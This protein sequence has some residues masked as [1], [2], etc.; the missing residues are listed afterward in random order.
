MPT[1]DALVAQRHV[2][3][4]LRLHVG[5][6]LLELVAAH[7]VADDVEEGQHARLASDR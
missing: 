4:R 2:G 1:I 3:G 6:V 5:Q 7:A